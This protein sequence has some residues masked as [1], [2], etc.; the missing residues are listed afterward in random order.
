MAK[1]LWK[2]RNLK[3]KPF[4]SVRADLLV[5]ER[6]WGSKSPWFCITGVSD[7]QNASLEG[8]FGLNVLKNAGFERVHLGDFNMTRVF[9]FW[10]QEGFH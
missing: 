3:P 1:P 8:M 7:A 6:A 5:F 10:P 4:A 2:I 9:L